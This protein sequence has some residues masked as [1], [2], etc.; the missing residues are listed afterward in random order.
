MKQV[1]YQGSNKKYVML[2]FD[3]LTDS[4]WDETKNED[5]ILLNNILVHNVSTTDLNVDYIMN[6]LYVHHIETK[7]TRIDEELYYLHTD[8]LIIDNLD[9]RTIR[10]IMDILNRNRNM[11]LCQGDIIHTEYFAESDFCFELQNK[12]KQYVC[13]CCYNNFCCRNCC[14]DCRCGNFRRNKENV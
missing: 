9:D 3:Y 12:R 1:V 6:N 5:R 10:T 13:S 14:G 11:Y 8:V 7:E 2:T 4:D